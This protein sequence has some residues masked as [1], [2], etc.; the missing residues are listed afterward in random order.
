L[1][2]DTLVF[3][4]FGIYV[5]LL[6]V[7]GIN[8]VGDLVSLAVPIV[9]IVLG[10]AIGVTGIPSGSFPKCFSNKDSISLLHSHALIAS[11]IIKRDFSG[12]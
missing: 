10:S 1:F 3:L 4:H 8:P 9:G 6:I 7:A 11:A 12:R 2:L 5:K